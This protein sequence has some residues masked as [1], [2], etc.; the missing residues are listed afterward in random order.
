MIRAALAI[1]RSLHALAQWT[2]TWKRPA[3]C[4]LHSVGFFNTL[5]CHVF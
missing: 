3:L 5:I 2:A 1:E 4:V